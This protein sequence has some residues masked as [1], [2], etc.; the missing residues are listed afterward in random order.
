MKNK[1]EPWTK[2]LSQQNHHP[3]TT[4]N[5][6]LHPALY[7]NN[8]NPKSSLLYNQPKSLKLF[9]NYIQVFFTF[10]RENNKWEIN[11]R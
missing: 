8:N 11:N 2:D 4:T 5:S 6:Q 7:K 9:C 1:K 3:S 10:F